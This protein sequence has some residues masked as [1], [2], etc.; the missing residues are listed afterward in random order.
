MTHPTLTDS[1]PALLPLSDGAV[2]PRSSEVGGVNVCGLLRTESGL[3]AAARGYIRA[4]KALGTTVSLQNM[5]NVVANRA[6]DSTYTDFGHET[7]FDVNLV[8]VNADMHFSVVAEQGMDFFEGRYNIGVWAWELPRFPAKWFDRFAYYD[9]IWVGTSFIASALAPVSPVP[10]VRM[11]TVLTPTVVGSREIGRA[12]LGV[13]PDE[14]VF[15]FTFDFTSLVGRKNPMAV[16]EAFCR[17]FKP[18]D[19]ARLVVKSVNASANPE[20]LE[21]MRQRAEGSRVSFIDGYWS[22]AE[23]SDLTAACD[24]YV[25]LHRSEGTGLTISDAMALGKP[26]IATGWSGNTDFMNVSNSYPVRYELVKLSKG[27][28]PYAAGETWA[29]PSVEHAAELMRHVFEHREEAA[30]RGAVAKRDI[31]TDFSEAA[32]AELIRQR[33]GAIAIR[34]KLASFRRGVKAKYFAYQKLLKQFNSAVS[35]AI[36]AGSTVAVI[37]R[38]D[39]KLLQL[40]GRTAWHFPQTE[41]GTYAGHYPAD[42]V[43]AVA[44]LESLVRRGARFLVIPETSLWWLEHYAEFRQHLVTN[45][46]RLRS[47][48]SCMIYELSTRRNNAR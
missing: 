29:E 43:E 19:E 31:E 3:G 36:P 16:V 41:S 1:L 27:V 39:E 15:L 48:R 44:Q 38:G 47:S 25:S 11:P 8:C 7:A 32:V 10:I 28:G 22:A 37:S 2:A 45:C 12:R 33:F 42:G 23:V 6:Q 34:R 20:D 4:L 18:A 24:C 17:A 46:R 40:E 30:C 26:V 9:E 14:F 21:A 35:R 5:S 13:P